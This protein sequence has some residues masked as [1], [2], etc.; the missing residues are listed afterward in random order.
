M[1][2]ESADLDAIQ[3]GSGARRC[4]PVSPSKGV[5]QGPC[6]VRGDLVGFRH[7]D[8]TDVLRLKP[9]APTTHLDAV[10]PDEEVR[11]VGQQNPAEHLQIPA[12]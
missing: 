7:P 2:P 1:K 6:E 9:V 4:Q 8:L 3:I 5:R 10:G 11:Y 12:V